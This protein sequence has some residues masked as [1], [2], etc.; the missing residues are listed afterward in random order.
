MP[1]RSIRPNRSERDLKRRSTLDPAG[2]F[3]R[4]DKETRHHKSTENLNPAR[5]AASEDGHRPTSTDMARPSTSH[6]DDGHGHAPPSP[7]VQEH[8]PNTKRFSL[9]RFR[10]ASDSQLSAKAKEHS[11][12]EAAPPVPAVP[13]HP[14]RTYA[15]SCYC[16]FSVLT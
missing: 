8:T 7:P 6:D 1:L 3:K 2:L 4:P 9:M 16:L 11:T 12:R 10:H 13:A 5:V 15:S 14:A